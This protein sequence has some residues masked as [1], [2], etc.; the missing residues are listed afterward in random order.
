MLAA[1][2]LV[3]GLAP[4]PGLRV[5]P[6]CGASCHDRRYPAPGTCSVCGMKLVEAS[7]VDVV[8]VALIQDLDLL[9]FGVPA[10]I[11][12]ASGCA[13]V[14]SVADTRDP[15]ACQE[16]VELGP[17]HDTGSAPG[18]DVLLIPSSSAMAT[19]CEDELW[20]DWVREQ[21]AGASAVIAVGNGVLLLARAG[22]LEGARVKLEGYPARLLEDSGLDVEVE[23]TRGVTGTGKFWTASDAAAAGAAALEVVRR[24]W[25]EEAALRAS[26]RTGFGSGSGE[27]A[28]RE[29]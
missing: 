24:L 19:V 22:L 4:G 2:V 15:V 1:L 29:E 5:C 26:R 7:T 13:R 3:N 25:G 12:A 6:P 23:R 17:L 20:L 11:L 10:G 18:L 27:P 28:R 16:L 8:G 9:A 21:A 14:I